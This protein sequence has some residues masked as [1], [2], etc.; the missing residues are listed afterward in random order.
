[1]CYGFIQS[2]FNYIILIKDVRNYYY[3][4]VNNDYYDDKLLTNIIYKINS[5]GAV[6]T[7]FCQ[8]LLPKIEMIHIKNEKPEWFTK[9]ETFYEKC[10]NHNEEYTKYI[11]N[12]EFDE[13]FDEN[14]KIKSIIG[15]GSMGQVYHVYN[16]INK[17][18]EVIKVLHPNIKDN[19]NIFKKIISILLWFPFTRNKINKLLPFDIYKFVDDFYIQSNLINEANNLIKFRNEYTDNDF[20]I[21]PELLK[22]SENILIM[23]YEKGESFYDSNIDEYN[24]EKLVTIFNIFVRS[25]QILLN[26]NHGDLHPGNWKIR[27]DNNNY[28]L[29]FYDFGYCWSIENKIFTDMGPLFWDTFENSTKENTEETIENLCKI[30]Y[31]IILYEHKETDKNFHLK[32][33][34]HINTSLEYLKP[35]I[36]SPLDLLQSVIEFCIKESLLINTTLIQGFI[37]QMQI[38]KLFENYHLQS[39][40][41]N[42]ICDYEVFRERYLSILTLCKTMNIFPE[43]SEYIENKLNSKNIKV[44][45]LFDTINIDDNI[46]NLIKFDN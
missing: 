32:I 2:L 21:I 40:N 39:S 38:Q 37:L 8:W 20:I 9:L 23:S 5:C 24:K 4:V 1:M 18:E 22:I 11:F 25:N 43:Y 33:N 45:S 13:S 14:Y 10:P 7:K 46:K 41:E 15:S 16:I 36:I 35:W 31:Y 27:N 30:M 34:T 42:N 12:K 17:K 6:A 29:I 28:K 26:F 44:E 19:I 3:N